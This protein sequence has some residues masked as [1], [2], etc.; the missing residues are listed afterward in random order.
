M[1]TGN[2]IV[3]RSA[4]EYLKAGIGHWITSPVGLAIN[5]AITTLLG[6]YIA[7]AQAAVSYSFSRV[8]AWGRENPTVLFAYTATTVFFSAL[9]FLLFHLTQSR[10][11]SRIQTDRAVRAIGLSAYFDPAID[12]P[13]AHWESCIKILR[14]LQP[15]ELNILGVTG[16]E[17]FASN[18]APLHSLVDS[19]RGHIRILLLAPDSL[20]FSERVKELA[21]GKDGKYNEAKYMTLKKL[22][23]REYDKTLKYCR[24]LESRPGFQLRS[25]EVKTYV[26]RPIWKLLFANDHVWV[27]QY[28]VGLHVRETP[29]FVFRRDEQKTTSFHNAF[30]NVW[31]RRWNN[32]TS[33]TI[34]KRGCE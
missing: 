11:L 2:E 9:F 34:I 21:L 20:G 1:S 13:N 32:P 22:F 33:T 24:S 12:G 5:T 16:W 31:N 27:Q 28:S 30:S 26:D 19:F 6:T 8:I 14:Y 23:K 15:T 4:R 29:A 17:T 18:R 3:P 10:R 7:A 25:I